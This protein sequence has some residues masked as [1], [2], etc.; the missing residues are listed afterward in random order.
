MK[1]YKKHLALSTYDMKKYP[2]KLLRYKY[3]YVKLF[4]V[5]ASITGVTSECDQEMS[6]LRITDQLMARR[7][8]TD[9]ESFVRGVQ[10]F[11]FLDE[12]REDPN[13]TKIGPLSAHQRN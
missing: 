3:S 6:Q 8:F 12:G 11:F 9:Q 7:A 5:Y 2:M 10:L 13:T 1:T 4:C